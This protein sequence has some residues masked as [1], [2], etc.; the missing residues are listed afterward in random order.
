ML[1]A[2]LN[3][4]RPEDAHPALPVQARHLARETLAWWFNLARVAV[5]EAGTLVRGPDAVPAEFLR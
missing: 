5:W 2:A 4:S 1:Q 3:G